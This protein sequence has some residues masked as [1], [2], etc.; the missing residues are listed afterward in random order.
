MVKVSVIIAAYRRDKELDRL[1]DALKKQTFEDFEVVIVHDGPTDHKPKKYPFGVVYAVNSKNIGKCATMNRAIKSASGEVIAQ[2]DDDCIP[3]K[4]WLEKGV[5]YF[6]NKNVVGVEGLIYTD[7]YDDTKYRTV[8][9]LYY[10]KGK[11]N[12]YVGFIGCNMFFRTSTL[13]GI[14]GYDERFKPY[15][16]EDSD[17]AWRMLKKGR[18]PFAK[19]VKVFHPA[20]LKEKS[21]TE[22]QD[23]FRWGLYV[24]DALLFKKH[25]WGYIRLIGRQ[26]NYLAYFKYFIWGLITK[27]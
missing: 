25:P 27:W 3:D 17:L 6:E 22:E 19:E 15:F 8:H 9:N 10:L 2:T 5:K 12:K 20:H 26:E 23:K 24:N 16:R 11:R 13:R 1:L 4:D 21:R 18:I 7:H 14:G